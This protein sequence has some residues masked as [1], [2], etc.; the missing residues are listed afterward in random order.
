MLRMIL[1]L[2]EW[3][4]WDNNKIFWNA[5]QGLMTTP[6]TT[7]W[8]LL[9]QVSC[10]PQSSGCHEALHSLTSSVQRQ[11]PALNAQTFPGTPLWIVPLSSTLPGKFQLQPLPAEPSETATPL[12]VLP[13]LHCR[14]V[15]WQKA[16]QDPGAHLIFF[17]SLKDNNLG[18][19]VIQC[20]ER[21]ASCILTSLI[22]GD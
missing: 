5:L 13:V 2:K 16:G 20:L 17:L 18:L 21:R 1:T 12:W 9:L 11:G 15:S 7:E 19:P 3:P 14:S 4:F 22:V 8:L 6:S 10:Q